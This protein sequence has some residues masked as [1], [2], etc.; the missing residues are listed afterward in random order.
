MATPPRSIGTVGAQRREMCSVASPAQGTLGSRLSNGYA[1]IS[2]Q[3]CTANSATAP[4]VQRDR[5]QP[6]NWHQARQLESDCSGALIGAAKAT[7]PQEGLSPWLERPQCFETFLL[8]INAVRKRLLCH[9]RRCPRIYNKF[10]A[11]PCPFLL[12]FC[13]S[14]EKVGKKSK[15]RKLT[16]SIGWGLLG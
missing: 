15:Y 16:S 8:F 9:A 13:Q 11:S 10:P 6:Y 3:Q 4:C 1:P 12:V 5:S 2:R 14:R 7:K